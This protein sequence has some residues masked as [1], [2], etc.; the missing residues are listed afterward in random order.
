MSILVTGGAGYIGSHVAL[1]LL[2]RG[3]RV[4]VLDSL[5]TGARALVP[6]GAAFV[7]GDI[8]DAALLGA[9]IAAHGV[10]AVM[11]FAAR[12]SVAESVAEP[13]LYYRE[14]TAKSRVL[15][16]TILA[17]G[18]RRFVFSSTA[19][20]YGD[21]R[22]VPIAEDAPLAPVSPY[23]RSKLAVEWMLADAAAA[24]GLRHAALRYFNVAGADPAGRAGQVGGRPIHLIP[25]A[26][27][28]ALGRGPA[29][30]IN[31]TDYPTPDG[32]CIRDYVHVSDLAAAHLAA[33]D[34]LE[35]PVPAGGLALNCGYGHG[36]SV[37]EVI[38]AVRRVT[39]LPLPA[40]EGARRPGDPAMLVAAAG[41]IRAELGWQPRFDD[42]DTIVSHALAWER[43]LGAGGLALSAAPVMHSVGGCGC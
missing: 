43:K 15:I 18:V 14:N 10:R 33:L 26:I 30:T 34:R 40:A 4:V 3:E 13:L 36:F 37:R 29:L 41:R 25:I 6:E 22:T 5:V 2:K 24:T 28:A 31:G 35:A 16:E 32:T 1:A 23:G 21:I 39:G 12:I 19:A 7:E 9:I 11:H 17:A 42:L 8:G 38:G 27:R 20:V